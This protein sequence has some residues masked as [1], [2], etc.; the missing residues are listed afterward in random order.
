MS[1]FVRE[2]HARSDGVSLFVRE[3]RASDVGV[4]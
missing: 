4:S 1:L 3:C 2:C